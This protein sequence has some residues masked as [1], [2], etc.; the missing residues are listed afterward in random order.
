MDRRLRAKRVVTNK[1]SLVESTGVRFRVP[2]LIRPHVHRFSFSSWAGAA[3]S[4]VGVERVSNAPGNGNGLHDLRCPQIFFEI[5]TVRIAGSNPAVFLFDI[6]F[7]PI[8]L[9]WM[10]KIEAPQWVMESPED[11][12][13]KRMLSA[14]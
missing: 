9:L 1:L 7:F 11:F 2:H 5:F 3:A 12:D 6:H 14:V 8:V 4:F 10:S 13:Q